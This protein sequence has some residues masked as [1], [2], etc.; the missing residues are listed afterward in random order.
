[1]EMEQFCI[2]EL[3]ND[4]DVELSFVYVWDTLIRADD[5]GAT[6]KAIVQRKKRRFHNTSDCSNRVEFLVVLIA[7]LAKP[8]ALR[9]SN[10]P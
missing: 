1:M 8:A 2:S 7:D 9:K 3:H 10:L 4:R 5:I 6:S